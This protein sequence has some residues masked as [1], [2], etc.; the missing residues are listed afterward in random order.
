[1]SSSQ[2]DTPSP[3]AGERAQ[4]ADAR[5]NRELIIDAAREQFAEHGLEAQIEHIARTA[6]VGVGTVYRH[7]PTKEALLE[8]LAQQRF[9]A[10]AEAAR[11]ALEI[12]DPWE[13]F[14]YFMTS[15]T[16][17]TAG[18]L[19]LS[20]AMGQRPGLCRDAADRAGLR[21]LVG[22]LVERAHA[23]GQ[24][25]SDITPDDVPSLVSGVGHAVQAG[26]RGAPA[27]SW[28][29]YLEIILAGV[30]AG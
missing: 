5:R 17:I 30:R 9:D 23:S 7:F 15:A 3:A 19:A 20:E 11:E 13:G 22:E 25:R 8:A 27:M 4:R 16:R 1:M 21:E 14:V 12:E 24:L 26:N 6:G 29:R 2:I 28:D 10:K 18:D